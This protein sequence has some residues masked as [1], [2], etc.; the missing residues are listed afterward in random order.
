MPGEI[1]DLIIYFRLIFPFRVGVSTTMLQA[2][3]CQGFK[4]PI[5]SAF[6]NKNTNFKNE[7]Q[8]KQIDRINAILSCTDGQLN[9]LI[10]AMEKYFYLFLR[11]KITAS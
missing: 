9:E 1:Q 7:G 8:S 2:L 11:S 5:P 4:G 10:V 3:G 6:R